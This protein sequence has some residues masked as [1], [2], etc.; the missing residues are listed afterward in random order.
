MV[1]RSGVSVHTRLRSD[2][3]Y[4][5]FIG[6]SQVRKSFFEHTVVLTSNLQ[7]RRPHLEL[8]SLS[9]GSALFAIIVS[10]LSPMYELL[11]SPG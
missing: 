5:L 7:T 10:D 11:A 6:V 8:A 4:Q 9:G 1:D 3:M 2:Q